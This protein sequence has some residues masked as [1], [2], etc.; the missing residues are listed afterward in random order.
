MEDEKMGGVEIAPESQPIYDVAQ[1]CLSLFQKCPREPK[2]GFGET[3][4]TS[5][6]R[7]RS[8]AAYLGVFALKNVSLDTRLR[9]E[10]EIRDLAMLLLDVCRSD[11]R[12]AIRLASKG[13]LIRRDSFPKEGAAAS[14]PGGDPL[15][16]SKEAKGALY[17]IVGSIDRLHR[18]AVRIRT[19]SR[20]DQKLE[21]RV[22]E[23]AKKLMPDG[24]GDIVWLILKYKFPKA[25]EGLIEKLTKSIVFRRHRLLYQRHHYKKLSYVRFQSTSQTEQ[26][27]DSSVP[28][29]VG[30]EQQHQEK[31][32]PSSQADLDGRRKRWGKRP[33]CMGEGTETEFLSNTNPTLFVRDRFDRQD[34][35]RDKRPA[36]TVVTSGSS[37]VG[38]IVYPC[39]PKAEG[40]SSHT[41]CPFCF[42]ELRVVDNEEPKWWKRHVDSDLQH[43]IC[44]SDQCPQSLHY[45][46]TF[47]SWLDHMESEH[48]PDWPMFI[49]PNSSEWRCPLPRCRVDTF[50]DAASFK[51]HI[52]ALHSNEID[53]SDLELVADNSRLPQPRE[54]DLCPLC[55]ESVSKTLPPIQDDETAEPEGTKETGKTKQSEEKRKP[56]KAVVRFVDDDSQAASSGETEPIDGDIKQKSHQPADSGDS[57]TGVKST[58][59]MAKHISRH[60]E[61]ISFLSLRGLEPD[62]DEDSPGSGSRLQGSDHSSANDSIAFEC[63]SERAETFVSSET[64]AYVVRVRFVSNPSA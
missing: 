20:D 58:F 38:K 15:P 9:F 62:D 12:R 46:S 53:P 35:I 47:T 50:P 52:A 57:T 30:G 6:E 5:Q 31:Q 34:D 1:E 29:A 27:P 43:F 36:P 60:L 10:P 24:F 56:R 13:S 48:E 49:Y 3:L 2:H 39:A 37:W 28:I 26:P 42:Q 16:L 41:T 64:W 45:F 63:V 23:F 18:L 54:T 7:F 61:N 17:G 11:L 21:E 51:E 25:N 40:A 14:F 22:A 4:S 44:L 59:T 55:H 33:D 32:Q 19:S 8:W